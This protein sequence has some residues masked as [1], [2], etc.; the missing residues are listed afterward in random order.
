MPVLVSDKGFIIYLMQRIYKQTNKQNVS[1]T[2]TKMS[3]QILMCCS[4]VLAQVHCKFHPETVYVVVSSP[5]IVEACKLMY[6]LMSHNNLIEELMIHIDIFV[7]RS[8]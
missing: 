6:V 4:V 5:F 1:M 3:C 7:Q 2:Q 8:I